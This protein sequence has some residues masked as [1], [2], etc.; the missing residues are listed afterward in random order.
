MW[1]QG[2]LSEFV[3]I[4][5]VINPIGVLP[6]FL[7]L[8]G[9]LDR[10]SQ[11]KLAFNAVLIAFVVLVFFIFAGAFLLDQMGVSIGAFQISGGIVLFLVAM[12]MIRGEVPT[13]SPGMEQSQALA[14]YPL[15]I[16]K[17]A[18]P[19]AMIAIILFSDDDRF[20]LLGQLTTVGIL[21]LVLL[22]QLLILFAASP[23][24]RLIGAAGAG[25]IGR[26]MGMLLTALAVSMVLS[27]TGQWLGLPKL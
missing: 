11:K 21:A 25:V 19:G 26:I 3:T 15:G 12:E 23:I 18:G 6:V 5:L 16:P 13:T 22:I 4:F 20:N 24:L 27:A 7:A 17:I 14:V 2:R 1:W 8:A 10:R 9:P